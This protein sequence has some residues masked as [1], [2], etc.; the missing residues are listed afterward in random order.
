MKAADYSLFARKYTIQE[1]KQ[2]SG[3]TDAKNRARQLKQI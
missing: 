1:N 2:Q 3:I